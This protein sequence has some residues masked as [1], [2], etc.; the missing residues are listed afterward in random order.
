MTCPI[1]VEW[2]EQSASQQTPGLSWDPLAVQAE[3]AAHL[4]DASQ[5]AAPVALNDAVC[6]LMSVGGAAALAVAV[7]TA[8]LYMAS[9]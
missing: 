6:M 8:W 7:G 5:K 4:A 9:W 3:P 2:P 1:Q